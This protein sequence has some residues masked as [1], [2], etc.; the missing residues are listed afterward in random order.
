MCVC[1]SIACCEPAC[2]PR[3]CATVL[4]S[5]YPHL[6][7][8]GDVEDARDAQLKRSPKVETAG[9]QR[10]EE[11]DATDAERQFGLAFDGNTCRVHD[12]TIHEKAI[13]RSEAGPLGRVRA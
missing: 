12:G 7:R 2:V 6:Y 5:T 8:E 13:K 3:D 9:R 1:G 11:M 10:A 4:D